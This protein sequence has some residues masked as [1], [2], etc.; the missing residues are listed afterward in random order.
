[1]G[2][3]LV[4]FLSTRGPRNAQSQE[5]SLAESMDNNHKDDINT[6]QPN[7]MMMNIIQARTKQQ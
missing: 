2:S 5:M 4:L 7:T 6:Q 1:M 3:H